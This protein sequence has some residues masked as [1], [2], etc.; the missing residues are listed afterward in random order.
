MALRAVMSSCLLGA[1]CRYDG[2]SKPYEAC[3]AL[4]ERLRAQGGSGA[5][6]P[7]CP[8]MLGGLACPRPPAERVGERVI[9]RDGS[10]VTRAYADGAARSVDIAHRAG[11]TLAILKAKSP[12]CGIGQI[13][14]GTFS[15]R[16]VPGDGVAAYALR[17]GGCT[18]VD[19]RLVEFCEPSF[20]H[21]VAIV[22]GSG[23]GGLA[24]RV[25]AV[26]RIPYEDIDGFPDEAIPVEGHRF[27]VLVGTIEGVPVV[28]YPGRVHLY[29][30]YSALEVTSLVRHAHRLGCRDIILTCASGA[31]GDKIEPGTVGIIS[32]QINL[33]GVNPLASAECVAAAEIEQPFVA[34]AGA[35]SSYL[36]Q[37]ARA[38]A[39]DAGVALAQGVYAGLLGPSYETVAEVR[40]LGILG[41]DYVGMSTVCEAIM[42]HALGMEMF[43]LTIVT[44]RAG[45]AGNAHEEVLR[46]A[47]EAADDASAVIM[48]VLRY[49]GGSHA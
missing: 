30:G 13:Y 34:M 24:D 47:D 1:P 4:A 5:L 27:E 8:E 45:L 18:V 31:I 7:I 17:Q 19:E 33:T 23:L 22:L 35:Y 26:R 25:R 12:S 6:T 48:G 40:A 39:D 36:S 14:D 11:A 49:L 32:D 46:C 2:G 20:E 29:Q 3:I 42:A 28:V 16:L 41:A 10:D 44:N 38:A 43:G 9:A 37:F 15:G 21:P